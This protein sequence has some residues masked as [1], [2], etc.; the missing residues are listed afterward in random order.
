MVANAYL[1]EVRRLVPGGDF[2]FRGQYPDLTPNW[3]KQ[4]GPSC[5]ISAACYMTT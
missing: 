1:P 2:L 4:V 5:I 3:Y